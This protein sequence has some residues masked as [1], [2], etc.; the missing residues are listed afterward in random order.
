MSAHI[1]PY[2]GDG[3]RIDPTYY[4]P[5]FYPENWN[6]RHNIDPRPQYRGGKRGHRLKQFGQKYVKGLRTV[7]RFAYNQVRN[8]P[9]STALLLTGSPYALPAAVLGYG[10]TGTYIPES[11]IQQNMNTAY[12]QAAYR[13]MESKIKRY[14]SPSNL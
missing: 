3:G 4:S 8:Q 9:I 12:A 5:P 2:W 13:I 7:G 1:L 6:P 14:R 11:Q 10:Y